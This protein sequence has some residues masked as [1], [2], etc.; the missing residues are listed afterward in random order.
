MREGSGWAKGRYLAQTTLYEFKNII[1]GVCVI[2]CIIYAFTYYRIY[3]VHQ[4]INNDQRKMIHN[5]PTKKKEVPSLDSFPVG[6]YKTF[7]DK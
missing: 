5:L 7:R 4:G 1:V 6:F 3:K 2:F